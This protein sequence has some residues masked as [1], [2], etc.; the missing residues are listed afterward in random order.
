[1]TFQHRLGRRVP[2]RPSRS[3]VP[4]HEAGKAVVTSR[5]NVPNGPAVPM[6]VRGKPDGPTRALALYVHKLPE[7]VAQLP[8]RLLALGAQWL[9][10]RRVAGEAQAQEPSAPNTPPHAA[11]R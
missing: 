11:R 8:R 7:R 1:M 6:R 10:W 2:D 5:H 3:L 4:V 9:F